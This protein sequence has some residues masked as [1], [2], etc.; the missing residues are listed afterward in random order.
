MD[1]CV[2]L[3]SPGDAAAT[4]IVLLRVPAVAA[5]AGA[6]A[7]LLEMRGAAAAAGLRSWEVRRAA[8]RAGRPG[9]QPHVSS[10]QPYTSTGCS[11][12]HPVC[13]PTHAGCSPVLP[14]CSPMFS[15]VPGRV[16]VDPGPWDEA[17][18]S[19]HGKVRRREV[20]RR[21]GLG[22]GGGLPLSGGG[23]GGGSGGPDGANGRR[24]AD[25][26]SHPFSERGEDLVAQVVMRPAAL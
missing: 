4:A 16:V 10:L 15:Q 2:L 12:S 6:A 11:T 23:G 20:A 3:A 14:G 13:S 21:N 9:L 5:G 17:C 1:R 22:P 19:S 8:P 26:G 7:V 25:G 18:L 24:G